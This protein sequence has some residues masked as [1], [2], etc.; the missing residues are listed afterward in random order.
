M[1]DKI[2]AVVERQ[3]EIAKQSGFYEEYKDDM[4]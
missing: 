4:E 3:E 1:K 2:L